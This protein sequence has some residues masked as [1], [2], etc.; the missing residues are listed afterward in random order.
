[1]LMDSLVRSLNI[2]TVNIGM[3]IGLKQVIAKQKEMGW[4]D[5]EIPAY[6]STLLGSYSISPYDVTKS[7]Q[8]LANTGKR[9]PLTTIEAVLNADDQLIYQADAAQTARQVLPAEAAV[10]TLYAM[11]Q[12]VERGTARS[13]QAEFA[14]LRLAGKTGTTNN[15]RDTWF[16]GVD[17]KHVTTVWLGKD[18]NGDTHLTGS[19]GALE[20]YKQY[21]QRAQPSA[22]RLPST[23]AMQWV[24]INGFGSW[25]C[26]SARQIPVWRDRGQ[27]F[28][29]GES[30]ERVIPVSPFSEPLPS[31]EIAPTD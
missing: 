20:V 6:P 9:V 7:Y 28:C 14:D 22:F 15:A 26:G 8:T 11:Q 1:M 5:A 27:R 25:D 13:L 29:Q 31:E 30:L 2:P 24:G 3:K 12:V 16:V 19:S 21:L 4:D 10:Q 23:T 18:N 17:G